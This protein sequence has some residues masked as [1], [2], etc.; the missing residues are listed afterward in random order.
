MRAR[1]ERHVEGRAAR[2][3][4]GLLERDRLGVADAVVLVPAL[5][6]DL[7]VSHDDRADE[8]MVAGLAASALG[9]LERALEVGHARSWTR[10]R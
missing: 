8:R 5:P 9:Q 3:V 7:A 1:L 4:A 10:P 2:R 6:H